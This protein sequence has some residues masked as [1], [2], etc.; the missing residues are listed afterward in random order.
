MSSNIYLRTP[1]LIYDLNKLNTPLDDCK[2]K[3]QEL[4]DIDLMPSD[5]NTL[6]AACR[7]AIET[8]PNSNQKLGECC[9]CLCCILCSAILILSTNSGQNVDMNQIGCEG[10]HIFTMLKTHS[11]N[12]VPRRLVPECIQRSS[13]SWTYKLPF[14]C[15]CSLRHLY[16][17]YRDKGI[18]FVIA[19]VVSLDVAKKYNTLS[20]IYH[21][22]FSI[23]SL[24]GQMWDEFC[25]DVLIPDLP[26]D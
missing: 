6:F 16:D 7:E 8:W 19:G 24:M 23:T 1:G 17:A 10:K 11:G 9:E 20:A 15:Y 22:Q 13:V 26:S 4:C 5:P 12:S 14:N 3:Y 21:E 2:R 25:R 18:I